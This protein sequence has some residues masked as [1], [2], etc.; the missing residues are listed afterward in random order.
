MSQVEPRDASDLGF[1]VEISSGGRA[2]DVGTPTSPP[3]EISPV[4]LAAK[5]EA[6]KRRLN[7]AL[8]LGLLLAGLG[9]WAW[10]SNPNTNVPADAVARVNGEYIYEA[11]ITREIDLS[12]VAVELSKGNPDNVPSRSKVLEDLIS[13]KMQVQDAKKA[14]VTASQVEVDASIS[15]ITTRT[16]LSQ[17]DLEAALAKYNLKL[18]D[19]RAV[20]ADIV[21]INRYIGDYVVK[22][23][24]SDQDIQTRRNDWLTQLTQTSKV[25]RLKSSG[26]GPEPRVGS[27]APD[28]SLKDL[29]GKEVKLSQ[30]RGR[31]VMINFWATWCPPC[32]QEIPTIVQT[33]NETHNS[34]DAYEIL[35]VATQSDQN[36]IQAFAKEFNIDFP[37]LP[38]SDN[39]ITELYH[40]LPIPTSFFIDRD[41]IIRE[42]HVGI[43]ERPQ[44]EKWLLGE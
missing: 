3:R 6:R 41:G 21:I 31:P 28:F 44:L 42:I 1:E 4:R 5:A 27:E 33:Y 26:S 14:G 12:R 18:D 19:M 23:A 2:H 35:G 24:T 22:G 13:R 34:A 8:V 32:R 29:G 40:V 30:L 43:V 38:D 7:I 36:T 11:D 9:S 20:T 15:D 16:G 37:V 10:I 25:D 17:K 39:S